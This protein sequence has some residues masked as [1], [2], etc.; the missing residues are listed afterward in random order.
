MY[1]HQYGLTPIYIILWVII[2]YC[3]IYLLFKLFQLRP[4]GVLSVVFCIPLRY[5]A[6]VHECVL[7]C[8]TLSDFLAQQNVPGLSY[9]FLAP[10]LESAISLRTFGSLMD[11][12]IDHHLGCEYACWYWGIIDFRPTHLQSKSMYQPLFLN[13][14]LTNQVLTLF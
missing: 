2:Q 14:V 1:L 6:I 10:V 8:L 12:E 11:D 9:I 4:L 13:I 3:G 5:A 7:A